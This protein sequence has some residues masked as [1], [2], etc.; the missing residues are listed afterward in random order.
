M[1]KVLGTSV[2]AIAAAATGFGLLAFSPSSC[3]CISSRDHLLLLAHLDYS[4]PEK[5]GAYSSEQIEAGL[6][7]H[8]LG[9]QMTPG[10]PHQYFEKCNVVSGNKF[11]CNVVAE[12]SMLLSRGFAVT[13]TVD[14]NQRMTD[15]SV[16]RSWSWL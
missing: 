1:K 5:A 14:E 11:T 6:K 9:R 3:G 7:R 15:V 2:L 16:Q 8:M 10:Q 13:V 4:S 12:T